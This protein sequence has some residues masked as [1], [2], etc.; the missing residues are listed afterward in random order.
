MSELEQRDVSLVKSRLES[1]GNNL[2]VKSES[3]PRL[4]TQTMGTL[5]CN[6]YSERGD[7]SPNRFDELRWFDL[8]AVCQFEDIQQ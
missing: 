7:T 6:D 8:E 4:G 5:K 3:A 1:N 2:T